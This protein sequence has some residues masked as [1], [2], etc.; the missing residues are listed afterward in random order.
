MQSRSRRR[1]LQLFGFGLALGVTPSQ[2]RQ[3][4]ESGMGNSSESPNAAVA[5]GPGEFVNG[6]YEATYQEGYAPALLAVGFPETAVF[7][8]FPN[9]PQMTITATEKGIW[10]RTRREGPEQYFIFN[11]PVSTEVFGIAIKDWL[12]RLENS[13]RLLISFT[14]PNGKLVRATQS[15]QREGYITRLSFE[16]APQFAPIRVWTRVI[17]QDERKRQKAYLVPL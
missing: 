1:T 15:F 7:A 5:V 14:A 2:A 10:L 12:V 13:S 6:T 9:R 8:M 16:G 3:L 4:A 11:S 17:A